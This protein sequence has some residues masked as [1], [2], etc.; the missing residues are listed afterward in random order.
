MSIPAGLPFFPRLLI[1]NTLR[2]TLSSRVPPRAYRS[3]DDF[4]REGA[5]AR[6][7]GG[8]HFRTSLE[9]GS[10]QGRTIADWILERYLRCLRE[11]SGPSAS[12]ETSANAS[13]ASNA[14][15]SRRLCP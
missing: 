5:A 15:L 10:R 4:A 1:P 2:R 13:S 6:I 11:R 12:H 7:V 3:F 8:M 14:A 9:V